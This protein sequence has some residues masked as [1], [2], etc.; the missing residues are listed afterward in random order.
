MVIRDARLTREVIPE[1]LFRFTDKF[2]RQ[3]K[4]IYLVGGA[5]RDFLI[6]SRLGGGDYDFATNA[7]PRE[8]LRL[9]RRTIPT[10]IAHGTVTVIFGGQNFEVTTYRSDGAYSDG[11][12]PDSVSFSD[13]IEEDLM[14]RDFT[15]N[16][17]ACDLAK[18]CFIDPYGGMEDLRNRV[19]RAVGDPLARFRDDGLRVLR[20]CRFA[21][22]LLFTID[23]ATEAAIPQ[24][25]DVFKQVAV[26]RVRDEL[27]KIMESERP[28]VALEAMRETGLLAIILPEL[29]EGYGVLQNEFH[30]HDIYYHNLYSCDA[31]G[32]EFPLVRV[33]A[34]L[35][36]VG[37]K[38]AL[39]SAQKRFGDDE[40]VFHNHENIGA[41][42]A[43]NALRR[44]K[45]SNNDREHIVHLIRHHMF[46][47]TDEWT[48]GAVRRLMRNAGV[49]NL[50][51]LF[52]LRRADRIGNGRKRGPSRSLQKLQQRIHYIMEAENAIS[53]RD[54][55]INGSDVMEV[56]GIPPGR[57]IGDLLAFLLE[58]IL[59]HPG[60]NTR[61]RLLQLADGFLR[62]HPVPHTHADEKARVSDA[63]A[64]EICAHQK[65][66]T[67]NFAAKCFD[68]FAAVFKTRKSED[69]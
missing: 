52:E 28:S 51:D 48:D 66:R 2:L 46:H 6:T 39:D 25:L 24:A 36:D 13:T 26:E 45:F 54:L 15:V 9:F 5:V 12:H 50:P 59:D 32:S 53:V 68:F 7:R 47:Y 40:T 4:E 64:S 41:R 67:Q 22:K 38:R 33:A 49:E 65:K 20:A 42:M 58:H 35:H 61:A 29:M 21:G 56:F 44:L 60:D 11:R 18:L 63:T 57:V 37:K 62:D 43:N 8:V 3:G 14:R 30:M 27:F 69:G 1:I 10:G 17:I 31:A 55:A 34:L 19:I 16:A 23:K